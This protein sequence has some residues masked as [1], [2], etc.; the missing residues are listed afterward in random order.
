[1]IMIKGKH[2]LNSVQFNFNSSRNQI[3]IEAHQKAT[4]SSLTLDVRR[5]IDIQLTH[6]NQNM[7]SKQ[8]KTSQPT[9]PITHKAK[10]SKLKKCSSKICVK[11]L[12]AAY[13]TE[14]HF[15]SQPDGSAHVIRSY[16][17]VDT[18]G[19]AID[20]LIGFI[21]NYKRVPIYRKAIIIAEEIKSAFID[22]TK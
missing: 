8:N 17:Q 11:D 5:K 14:C 12:I 2:S 7:P 16:H 21:H 15:N 20:D 1:M 18:V 3:R 10:Y 4:P 22:E 13:S 6:P 19:E 9:T